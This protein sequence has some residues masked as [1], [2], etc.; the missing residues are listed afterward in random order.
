MISFKKFVDG[1]HDAVQTAND[2]I[3]DKNG[4]IDSYFV[5]SDAD[6]TV[7]T[8]INNAIAAADALT[9]KDGSVNREDFARAKTALQNAKD[10]LLGVSNNSNQLDDFGDLKP[11]VVTVEYPYIKA[12]GTSDSTQVQVP[13]LTLSPISMS[14][15]EKAT[16]K[17][18]FDLEIV[19]EELQMNFTNKSNPSKDA[20]MT[21]GELE[22]TISPSEPAEGLTQLIEGYERV[23]KSQIPH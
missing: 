3:Q 20:N 21:R 19:N 18:T 23:L 10:A 12:D 8:N 4:F 7:L 11:K 2:S 14:H 15:I 5:R 9:N 6:D 13:L 1:V 22:I 16:I 17:A